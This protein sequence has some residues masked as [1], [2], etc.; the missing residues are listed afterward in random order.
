MSAVWKRSNGYPQEVKRNKIQFH[1]EDLVSWAFE[2]IRFQLK[3]YENGEQN[4][5]F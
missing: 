5:Q 3:L 2:K 1:S 4:I